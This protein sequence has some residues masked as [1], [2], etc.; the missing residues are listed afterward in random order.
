MA[1]LSK[2]QIFKK[3]KWE[4]MSARTLFLINEQSIEKN[5]PIRHSAK[6]AL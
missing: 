2:S 4:A 5:L 1:A 3:E 6:A